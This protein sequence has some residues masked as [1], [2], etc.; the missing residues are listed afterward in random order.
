M[1]AP[2]RNWFEQRRFGDILVRVDTAALGDT[3]PWHALDRIA[4]LAL[5]QGARISLVDVLDAVP[6][7]L[8]GD[9]LARRLA[10]HAARRARER[11]DALAAPLAGLA[12]PH[13]EV[14]SGIPFLVTTRLVLRR[15]HDL[16]VHLTRSTAARA[17]LGADD[18]HLAR[19]CPCPVWVMDAACDRPYR[20]VVVAVEPACA[21]GA[22]GLDG[23]ALQLSQTAALFAAL[24]NAAVHVIHAWQPYGAALLD[25][26]TLGLDGR[27]RA[28][29]VA[30]QRACHRASLAAVCSALDERTAGAARAWL[31]DGPADEVIPHRLAE[32]DADLLVMGTV[33]GGNTPGLFI[34]NTAE[35]ILGRITIPVLMLKP[36]G[37]ESPVRLLPPRPARA[38]V[39][40]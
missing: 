5:E 7:E 3:L 36:P 18:R 2:R 24:D 40:T 11:L 20:N 34:G 30:R 9:P 28:A 12:T 19:K 25:E 13:I 33:A 10:A 22:D 17:G 38:E 16:V 1:N 37:F 6:P 23:F 31:V 27:S 39:T 35:N 21:D 26:P 15:G 14:F 8:A 29:Y 32:L 4:R